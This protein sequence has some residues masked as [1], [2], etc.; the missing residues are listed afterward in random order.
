M[1]ADPTQPPPA[2]RWIFIGWLLLILWA[3]LPIGSVLPWAHGLLESWI[4]L[5]AIG[6]S[7]LY[8]TRR[9]RLTSAFHAARPLLLLLL[10]WCLL[11]ALQLLPLPPALLALLFSEQQNLYARTDALQ[12]D[13]SAVGRI[14]L[15]P[16]NTLENL[17][18]SIA[19]LLFLV[20]TLLLLNSS[21]RIKTALVIVIL[22]GVIQ[23]LY[24]GLLALHN[25]QVASGSF[26]NRNHLAGYLEICLAIGIGILVADARESILVSWR[27]RIISVLDWL[28]SPKLLLRLSL[29]LMVVALVLTQSRGGNTAFLFGLLLTGLIWLYLTRKR[30]SPLAVAMILSIL[31]IDILIIGEWFGLQEVIERIQQTRIESETRADLYREALAYLHDFA[32]LGSGLGS[33][34]T[35]FPQYRQIDSIGGGVAFLHAH[36]DYLE[37]ALESGLLGLSLL[38]ASALLALRTAWRAMAYRQRSLLQGLGFGAFMGIS[39]LLYHSFTDFNLRIPSNALMFM[40]LFALAYIGA[41]HQQRQ[42]RI[43][44]V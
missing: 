30:P 28:S 13:Q 20:L 25:N 24:G 37:F 34:A 12:G 11:I 7:L 9:T 5:L 41:Y 15:H 6:W 8:A 33:F 40:L 39:A 29:A 44:L 31:I 17:L 14:T 4:L 23:A 42:P 35:L 2:D 26:V 16:H 22:S 18:K 21:A 27:H 19:Y 1:N 36:N 32:L 43:R 10:A 38:A 3:P